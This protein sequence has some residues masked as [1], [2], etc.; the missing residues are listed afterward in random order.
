MSY[1][2]PKR[3]RTKH[4]RS[5]EPRLRP[6]LMM[7][8]ICAD[9]ELT[10]AA[11]HIG[12][13][14]VLVSDST[15]GEAR[16]TPEAAYLSAA[17]YETLARYSGRSRAHVARGL[18]ELDLAGWIARRRTLFGSVITWS[19][20]AIRQQTAM[21]KSAERA[22]VEAVGSRS[23]KS[24]AKELAFCPGQDASIAFSLGECRCEHFDGVAANDRARGAA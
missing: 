5:S 2:A 24:R 9:P 4:D 17:T 6:L 13:V 20:S 10:P 11:K 12:V 19:A 7:R 1:S 18:A 23:G 16:S 8:A 14:L 22:Y 3:S 15:R 21:R